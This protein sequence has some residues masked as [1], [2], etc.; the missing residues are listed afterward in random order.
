MTDWD[1]Y[2]INIAEAISKKSKDLE[3]KVGCVIV[4]GRNRIVA[5]GYNRF[6]SKLPENN[7]MWGKS[8]D[9]Y[10]NKHS[11][12]IHAEANAIINRVRDIDN[13]TLYS[14][15]KPCNECTK[16][17]AQMKISRIV[18]RDPPTNIKNTDTIADYILDTLKIK[19][20]Q[21]I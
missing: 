11:Y 19:C 17:I 16:L 21:V 5:T 12:V 13:C 14:T 20:E 3:C 8:N 15:R 1:T 10:K 18:Y 9:T 7:E 4:D 6:P 2:F